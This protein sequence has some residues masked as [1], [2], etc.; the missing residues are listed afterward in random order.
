MNSKDIEVLRPTDLSTN[1]W[2]RELCLQF[3]LLRE[4]PPE[5]VHVILHPNSIRKDRGAKWQPPSI[6]SRAPCG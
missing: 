2:L 3:A 6:S 4:K 1:A 5:P